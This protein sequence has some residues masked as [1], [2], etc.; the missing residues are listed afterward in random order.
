MSWTDQQA[1][2]VIKE[3]RNKYKIDTFVETGTFKG[4]NAK[5]HSKNFNL[6]MTCEKVNAYYEEA[7]ERLR[8]IKN[9]IILKKDSPQFLKDLI[10]NKYIYYLDAHFYD[11]KMPKGKGKFIV[12]K[13]L[14]SI[15]PTAESIIII[16]DFDNGLGHCCYDGFHLNMELVRE[17]LLKINN[18]FNFYTNTLESCDIVKPIA[19]EIRDAGLDVD[20]ETV[21][22]LNYAWTEP[23][24]TY[25][26]ILYCLPTK[27]NQIEM[28]ELGVRKWN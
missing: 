17:K 16:H 25:R 14:D 8:R 21:D 19:K 1:V 2:E 4:I 24:L 22:N 10:G 7:K 3:L 9:V 28:I 18:K 12:L 23:R 6:V 27:L 20:F 15:K 11:K 26:G 5:L 13:E